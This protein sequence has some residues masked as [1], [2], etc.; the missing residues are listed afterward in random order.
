MKFERV[1]LAQWIGDITDGYIDI[2][3]PLVHH[4]AGSDEIAWLNLQ[5]PVNCQMILDK[6]QDGTVRTLWAEF[7]SATLRT[8]Y[9]LRFGK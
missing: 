9:A 7:Y 2:P 1:Q 3:W 5:D 6:D 4:Q 8:E